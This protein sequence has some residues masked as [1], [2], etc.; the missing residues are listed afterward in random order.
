MKVNVNPLVGGVIIAI[1]VAVAIFFGY[2]ASGPPPK[3]YEPVDMKK[4]MGKA[5]VAPPAASP[6]G[7]R[8]AGAPGGGP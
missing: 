1:V 5:P 3:S 6:M 2:R 8:A 7:G 4:L